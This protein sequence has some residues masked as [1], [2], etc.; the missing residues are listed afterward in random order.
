MTA[1]TEPSG[2]TAAAEPAGP[3]EVAEPTGLDDWGRFWS[4]T[5]GGRVRVPVCSGCGTP[6]WYPASRCRRCG[7]A[8]FTWK[9]LSGDAEVFLEMTVHRDFTGEGRTVPYR[10]ALV[11]PAEHPSIRLL[12]RVPIDAAVAAGDPIRLAVIDG[13]PTVETVGKAG[14][15]TPAERGRS[16]GDG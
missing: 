14:A 15:R 7:A 5:A 2:P 13:V 11:V 9:A 6:N 8:V 10:V 3:I 12:A 1:P 16:D 4:H